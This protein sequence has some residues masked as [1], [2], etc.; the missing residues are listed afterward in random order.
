[1][2]TRGL[3]WPSQEFITDRM[4]ELKRKHARLAHE[5]GTLNLRIDK[6]FPDLVKPSDSIDPFSKVG[7]PRTFVWMSNRGRSEMVKEIRRVEG[8]IRIGKT[9]RA[10]R[11]R[12]ARQKRAEMHTTLMAKIRETWMEL[13]REAEAAV[14]NEQ[15]ALAARAAV[16]AVA[17]E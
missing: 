9:S 3:P 2:S 8:E 1:M 11:E 4:M 15:K 16:A 6:L 10:I 13:K 14:L 5:L 17:A 12:E 7:A